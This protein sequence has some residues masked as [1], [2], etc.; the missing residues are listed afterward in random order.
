MNYHMH[1][2]RLFAVL[3][4]AVSLLAFTSPAQNLLVNGDFENEPNW[5][6]RRSIMTATPRP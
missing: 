4:T 6:I 1:Q 2:R 5:G 3:A